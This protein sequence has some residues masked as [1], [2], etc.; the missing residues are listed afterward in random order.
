ME[1]V[2][3]DVG[4]VHDE[5]EEVELGR[6]VEYEHHCSRYPRSVPDADLLRGLD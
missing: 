6:V 2:E 1:G 5:E 3:K 4:A